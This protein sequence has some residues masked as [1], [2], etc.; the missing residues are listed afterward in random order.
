MV[1]LEDQ[2][3]NENLEMLQ[4]IFEVCFFPVLVMHYFRT[5]RNPLRASKNV[6]LTHCWPTEVTT[7]NQKD[8]WYYN[9]S[10]AKFNNSD[11]QEADEDGGGGLDMDEFRQAM[12]KTMAGKGEVVRH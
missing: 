6:N 7:P 3:N 12:I 2:M 9:L 1:R 5:F 4:Q 8:N 10:K 11:L